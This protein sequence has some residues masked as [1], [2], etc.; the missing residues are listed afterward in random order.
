MWER[1]GQHLANIALPWD[2]EK[3]EGKKTQQLS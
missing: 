1:S 2:G 3:M